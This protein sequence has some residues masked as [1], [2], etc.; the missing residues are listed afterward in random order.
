MEFYRHTFNYNNAETDK[1]YLNSVYNAFGFCALDGS[2]DITFPTRIGEDVDTK[3]FKWAKDDGEDNFRFGHVMTTDQGGGSSDYRNTVTHN[4]FE[5]WYK[6][7]SNNFISYPLSQFYMSGNWILPNK[8]LIFIP[9]KNNLFL[10]QQ[11]AVQTPYINTPPIVTS[12][13][14]YD[15]IKNTP[16]R[17]NTAYNLGGTVLCLKN[18]TTNKNEF[19]VVGFKNYSGSSENFFSF[20][21]VGYIYNLNFLSPSSNGSHFYA[22]GILNFSN[23]TENNDHN[24]GGVVTGDKR[25]FYNVNQ[26]VC[27][28]TRIP[29]E[30]GFV[31][32]MYLCTTYPCEDIEGKVF[33]FNGRTFLGFYENF[34]VELPA[35]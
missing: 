3:S 1:P 30:Q 29:Q 23:I 22:P 34:V 27:T 28:L 32:G 19:F 8:T 20:Q 10:L 26:N 14:F 13:N 25:Y 15:I 16:D 7:S 21:S 18:S 35:N 31:D 11:Y 4:S 2:S 6:I 24:T 17:I 12:K 9:L 5:L 33:S